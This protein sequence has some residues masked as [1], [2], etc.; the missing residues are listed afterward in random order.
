[1]LSGQLEQHSSSSP[2]AIRTKVSPSILQLRCDGTRKGITIAVATFSTLTS[3]HGPRAHQFHLW[4][5]ST[6]VPV[7]SRRCPNRRCNACFCQCL[8]PLVLISEDALP[9]D[10]GI[11]AWDLEAN[12]PARV[13]DFPA[14]NTTRAT[15]IDVLSHMAYLTGMLHHT[16]NGKGFVD[17]W[18]LPLHTFVHYQPLP[19]TKG[20][21]SMIP[22]LPN[23]TQAINHISLTL[24][25]NRPAH[26]SKGLDL[27]AMFDEN[28]LNKAKDATRSTA[29]QF[30]AEMM[31]LSLAV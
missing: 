11:Q 17:S 7:L 1:M 23:I 15:L 4:P 9:E 10:G 21:K 12:G 2:V 5:S 26:K 19:T 30:Q 3:N 8:R 6:S 31:N 14:D 13:L 27:P 18:C 24:A 22:F 16:V 20:T 29:A 25:F 28:F